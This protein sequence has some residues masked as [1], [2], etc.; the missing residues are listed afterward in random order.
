MDTLYTVSQ[1]AAETGITTARVRRLA[2]DLRLGRKMGRDRL[3]T[4]EERRYFL[5]RPDRR[6]KGSR[7]TTFCTD[8][9]T[10]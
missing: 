1:I 6:R 9:S 8:S 10:R 5:T 7:A 3:F 2:I 4:E